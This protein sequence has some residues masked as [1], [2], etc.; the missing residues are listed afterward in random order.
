MQN[1]S[2]AHA[3]VSPLIYLSKENKMNIFQK[4]FGKKDD[5][6]ATASV[7]IAKGSSSVTSTVMN[8]SKE[9]ITPL[10]AFEQFNAD[11]PALEIPSSKD[12]DFITKLSKSKLINTRLSGWKVDTTVL[13]PL[14]NTPLKDVILEILSFLPIV[15]EEKG[16]IEQDRFSNANNSKQ[17][18]TEGCKEEVLQAIIE[19]IYYD[20]NNHLKQVRISKYNWIE[21]IDIAPSFENENIRGTHVII[22]ISEDNYLFVAHGLYGDNDVRIKESLQKYW[23]FQAQNWWRQS[24]RASAM[25]DLCN[26]PI[27]SQ[28]T[29]FLWGTQILCEKCGTSF[30]TETWPGASKLNRDDI[31]DAR[32]YVGER[33]S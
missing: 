3:N 22:R 9:K 19:C 15:D 7:S 13:S 32:R 30:F 17:L 24:R 23:I 27:T 31:A 21:G 6:H 2:S 25:C 8:I 26:R 28:D 10:S 5:S 16:R 4:I 33:H 29:T 1:R 20:S 14:N 18:N 12:L 11:A